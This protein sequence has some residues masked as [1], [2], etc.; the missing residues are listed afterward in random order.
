MAHLL[1]GGRVGNNAW[2]KLQ[3]HHSFL[4][5]RVSL[6][7]TIFLTVFGGQPKIFSVD[8]IQPQG[9]P[10]CECQNPTK[11]PTQWL[12]YVVDST[13]SNPGGQGRNR[14]VD[15]RIF[16][17]LLYQLSYLATSCYP[18]RASGGGIIANSLRLAKEFSFYS[19]DS[20]CSVGYKPFSLFITS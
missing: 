8:R 9:S 17:P 20:A 13:E 2:G 3:H 5:S 19:F 16:N 7:K 1:V 11:S 15:T 14:T 4:W 10:R 12:G 18:V 6:G